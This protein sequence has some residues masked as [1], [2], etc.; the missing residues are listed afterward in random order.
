M[1]PLVHFKVQSENLSLD[2]F[3]QVFITIL[4]ENHQ[5]EFSTMIFNHFLKKHQNNDKSGLNIT[6]FSQE[7]TNIIANRP[8]ISDQDQKDKNEPNKSLHA[9]K[10]I[11]II[12]LPISHIGSFLNFE[13]YM[14]FKMCAREIYANT[15]ESHLILH[16][17]ILTHSP[18]T[19]IRVKSN[20]QLSQTT[21]FYNTFCF[22]IPKRTK[23]LVLHNSVIQNNIE[24]EYF[25]T[26]DVVLSI[27]S[28]K[29]LKANL[30]ALQQQPIN[31]M[32]IINNAQNIDLNLCIP[33]L[34]V[35]RLTLCNM[36][37]DCTKVLEMIEPSASV[38]IYHKFQHHE[39]A[40]N[41]IQR[42]LQLIQSTNINELQLFGST[43]CAF[44]KC[45]ENVQMQRIANLYLEANE[46]N[47]NS[48][49]TIMKHNNT[50]K[51]FCFIFKMNESTIRPP[52][53]L[54]CLV[55]MMRQCS[56]VGVEK[57]Q[58]LLWSE[59]DKLQN[60][61]IVA[62]SRHTQ[63]PDVAEELVWNPFRAIER[64]TSIDPLC[65]RMCEYESN[66]YPVPTDLESGILPIYAKP[67]KYPVCIENALRAM[68]TV[69]LESM[70][71]DDLKALF[72][73]ND[74]TEGKCFVSDCDAQIN[75]HYS[76]HWK[77]SHHPND[78]TQNT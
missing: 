28:S 25:A 41:T 47:I 15:K 30:L 35:K 59:D 76:S 18:P 1:E 52:E 68:S 56:K 65:K 75:N 13:S 39:Q 2:E 43:A 22:S 62:I 34:S 3:T 14:D 66:Y 51:E 77:Q 27:T 46:L 78:T 21:S 29:Q 48:I 72:K 7:I 55:S 19:S 58:L 26:L 12:D 5:S 54:K 74:L 37:D 70:E 73:R 60:A 17:G 49:D 61:T 64:A 36:Y 42:A 50:T 69:D 4:R 32:I 10:D 9:P 33:S 67:T 63:E 24:S 6:R 16:N 71:Y 23:T 8:R 44:L 20:A 38:S 11:H 57:K 40:Q 31:R 53:F 45:A